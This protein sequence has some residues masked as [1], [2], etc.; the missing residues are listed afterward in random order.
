[1]AD[2]MDALRVAWGIVGDTLARAD[3]LRMVRLL[4][5]AQRVAAAHEGETGAIAFDA[6]R[7]L[8]LDSSRDFC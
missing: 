3:R 6:S 2:K 5:I 8:D 1:M 7:P 4:E